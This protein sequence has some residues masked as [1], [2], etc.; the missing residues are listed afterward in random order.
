MHK[1][2]SPRG[3]SSLIKKNKTD[4]VVRIIRV[5]A[6]ILFPSPAVSVRILFC[7]HYSHLNIHVVFKFTPYNTL[8]FINRFTKCKNDNELKNEVGKCFLSRKWMG[9]FV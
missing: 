8:A 7:W 6:S 4:S 9:I 1:G 5:E 2:C 3:N